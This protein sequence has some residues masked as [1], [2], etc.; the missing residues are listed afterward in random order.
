MLCLLHMPVAIFN[1]ELIIIIIGNFCKTLFSGVPK[2]TALYNILQ[3]F[4]SFANV[5]H[6]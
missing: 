5:I 4:L 1:S 3:H 2:F 6:I